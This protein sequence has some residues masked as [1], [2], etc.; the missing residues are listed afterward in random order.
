MYFVLGLGLLLCSYF[1]NFSALPWP[2]AHSE[3]FAFLAAVLFGWGVI[4]RREV[5]IRFTPAVAALLFLSL[6]VG[7]Q[8]CFGLIVFWGDA[9][10]TLIYLLMAYCALLAGQV[11]AKDPQWPVSLALALLVAAVGSAIVGLAQSLLVWT[12]SGWVLPPTWSRRPGANFGQPNHLASLL[13]MGAA[14]LIYLDQ[15]LRFG[16]TIKVLLSLLLLIGIS[17][18]ESRTG[19]I[20]AI[21]LLL[22]WLA[23]RR[24]LLVPPKTHWII[25]M[26]AALIAGM[27]FWPPLIAFIHEAGATVGGAAL[28]TRVGMRWLVWQQL[29]DAVW[30]KPWFGWG[31]R[32]T[33][34]ALNAVLGSQPAS[35]P[36]TYAHNVVLDMAIGAGLPLTGLA[37]GLLCYWGRNR[38]RSVN[39][40]ETWYA[41]GLLIPLV[42][43]STLEYPYAYAYFLVPAMFAIGM[44]EQNYSVQVNKCISRKTFVG[45]W[46]VYCILLAWMS[47]EY[48]E[49]EE[50]FR[51]ARFES[52]NVG[53][54]AA[55]YERPTIILLT[56][57]RVL[58]QATRTVPHPGM[59]SAELLLLRSAASRFPWI[60]VQNTFALS[61]ALNDDLMEAQRQLR[62]IRAMHGEK[63]YAAIR[64]QWESWAREKYPQLVG[65]A[66][67]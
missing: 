36:Y 48:L 22:W 19:L 13:V 45:S 10:T 28:D 27:W 43:H 9:F 29:L 35:E 1:Q 54:T 7:I 46:L 24:A 14:S 53:K 50:D 25:A 51:V 57:L 60:P 34:F 56:Q 21:A 4:A 65:L 64:Q 11:F 30:V 20:S 58:I 47:S 67:K 59:P 2:A 38:V 62:I 37:L 42:I 23:R 6:L 8:Y 49:I 55:D 63:K 3:I 16:R 52:L 32:G 15:R 18:S 44:L 66:P 31:V 5:P 33:S 17:V 41:A 61:A 39:S 26:A 40:P 12:D